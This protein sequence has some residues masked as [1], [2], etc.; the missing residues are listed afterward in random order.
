MPP[1]SEFAILPEQ[2]PVIHRMLA[3]DPRQAGGFRLLT[4]N[5]D[6]RFVTARYRQSES[7]VELELFL[8]HPGD[9]IALPGHAGPEP[10][11]ERRTTQF[12]VLTRS[13]ELAP[14][15]LTSVASQIAEREAGFSW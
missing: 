11:L 14:A 4:V 8:V 10:L 1:R 12:R 9:D 2:A 5:I 6:K 7:G 3:L 15:L 13:A